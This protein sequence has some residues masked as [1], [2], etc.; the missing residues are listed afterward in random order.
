[1][2]CAD[3]E[4]LLC[5]YVDGSLAADGRSELERHLAECANCAEMARDV[6][7]AVKFI[8]RAADVEPPPELLTRILFNLPSAHHAR[9]ARPGGLRKFVDRWFQPMLQPRN[10]MGL[11]MTIL[12]FSLLGRWAGIS[13]RQL[14]L[15]D[16]RPAKVWQAIDDKA[17]RAWQRTEKFYQNLRFVYEIQTQL[18][19]WKQKEQ[20][21]RGRVAGEGRS[22]GEQRAAGE[23]RPAA[24]RNGRQDAAAAPQSPGSNGSQK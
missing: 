12:S 20:E 5:D 1:M 11:A 18:R 7:A 23:E 14:T 4:I 6:A 24:S 22:A 17:Y 15:D 21:L 3:L 16:L 13:P 19:E 8:D 9:A 2:N 10:A